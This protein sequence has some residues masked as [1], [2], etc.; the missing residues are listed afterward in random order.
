MPKKIIVFSALACLSANQA[1]A[2][3]NYA[4]K[5]ENYSY[6][7]NIYNQNESLNVDGE[8][9]KSPFSVNREYLISLASSAKSWSSI[10]ETSNYPQKPLV[11]GVFTLDDYNASAVSPYVDIK[12]SPYKITYTNA[13]I[14]NKTIIGP[15]EIT[16]FNIEGF[17]NIGLGIDSDNP[18][19]DTNNKTEA[20][21]SGKLADLHAVLLHEEMHSLGILSDVTTHKEDQ[22]DN[23]NYFSESK[24]DSLSVFDKDLR[25]YTGDADDAFDIEKEIV[26]QPEMSVGKN[27][28]FDIFEYAPYYIGENTLKTLSGKDNFADARTAIIQNGGLTNYSV[29]YASKEAYPQVYGMPIHNAD[30]DEIDLSHL[31]LHNSFMSHQSYRNWLIPME[32]ELA[33]MQDLGY[34]IDLRKYF[35]KSYYLNNMQDVYAGGY[36]EWNGSV[37]TGNP[38]KTTH[39]IGI[40]I[41]GNNNN[42]RQASDIISD[43]DAAIGVRVEGVKNTYTLQGGNKILLNGDNSVALAVT[44]GRDH[45]I[46]VEE[47]AQISAGGENSIAVGFDFGANLFGTLNDVRG[48]YINYNQSEGMNDEP[49][50]ETS[51]NLVEYFNVAGV[52]NGSRAAIYI[53]DNAYVKTISILQGAQIKGDIISDW[54][55][56]KSGEN[57]KVMIKQDDEWFINSSEEEN[58]LYFTDLNVSQYF[59]GKIQ[60][61]IN[62]NNGIYNTLRLN[63]KGDL[64][65]SGKQIAVNSLINDGN[66]D[67]NS[68]DISVAKGSIKGTGTINV[69]TGI[70]FDEKLDTIENTINLASNAVFSTMNDNIQDI[71]INQLNTDKAMLYFD[72]GDT[73]DLQAPSTKNTAQ[74]AQIKVSEN[75]A[76]QLKDGI[77]VKLFENAD[78]ILNL[79]DS[80]ANIYYDG[81]KYTLS[82]HTNSKD[83]LYVDLSDE[84]ATLSDALADESTANYIVTENKQTKDLG[85]VQGN[86]F[87]ISGKDVDIDNHKGL[88]VDG[89]KNTDGTVL[90][91]GIF[92]AKGA[93]VSVINKGKLAVIA[94]DDDIVLGKPED[95][96]LYIQN[97][98]VILDAKDNNIN[99]KGKIVGTDAQTD[100]LTALGNAVN[101]AQADNVHINVKADEVNMTDKS[102]NTIWQISL[103]TLNVE[104]D[105][106]L[107]AG[108]NQLV[109]EGGKINFA[110]GSANDI[111]LGKMILNANT[112]VDIDVDLKTQSADHFIFEK[113]DYLINND[114]FLKI[115]DINIQG[116]NAFLTDKEYFIPFVSTDFHNEN[117][118]GHAQWTG[119]YDILTP[120]YKYNLKYA[121]DE[122]QGGFM[123]SRGNSKQYESYN[124]AVTVAPVAAL[125][126]GYLSQLNAYGEAFGGI[127]TKN[128][129][130]ENS[131]GL[132]SGDIKTSKSAWIRPYSAFEKVDLKHA[133]KIKNNMYGSYFGGSGVINGISNGWEYQDSIYAGYNTSR[134][135]YDGNSIHQY[136]VMLGGL[137]AWYK[138]DFFVA[139]TA[140]IGANQAKAKTMYGKEDF[141]MLLAG[142]AAKTGYNWRPMSDK[143]IIQANYQM[144]Y[145]FV[146]TFNYKNAAGVRIKQDPLHAL[147]L[148]PGIKTI[149]NFASGWQPYIEAQMVWSLLNKTRFKAQNAELPEMSVKPYA[150]YGIGLQKSWQDKFS[151]YGQTMFRSGG[152][153]GVD[154]SAEFRWNF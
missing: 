115:D 33:V 52:L 121:E 18:G 26:P 15:E 138:N 84:N 110:N 78:N 133:P 87:E 135:K 66:L 28:D 16:D 89:T 12:E 88:T 106:N 73:Y 23:T 68:I 35:G 150:Q 19:W 122:Q 13:R 39:G 49:D 120:I 57:A 7:F 141:Y 24:N 80:T 46:N 38:S 127:D 20:L 55:S 96:T 36:S 67:V 22:G 99:I 53:A 27:E 32:A 148:A 97:G 14:N 132:A 86:L 60:G 70:S 6:E 123:L 100:T 154:I 59:S 11:Y 142:A 65:V 92:N 34:N 42:I 93:D 105:S 21:Y 25:I 129:Y 101:V 91:T 109:T 107:A 75:M 81:K 114:K 62:G 128:I 146:N 8:V 5:G 41:Y 151:V 9:L 134:Q 72:L 3:D 1:I 82:Q 111:I 4:V 104:Q 45:N 76:K 83:L 149:Y 69:S 58:T 117:L 2:V 40:H 147:N 44:W 119:N 54:N 137:R 10:I 47:N 125:V 48:S 77:A 79:A 136:G 113:S 145:S 94:E 130:T 43:G 74:I 116:K 139:A 85:T 153:K 64:L 140:N 126:G 51:A 37:Y 17:I 90:K 144:S 143:W 63:N 131:Q 31:E 61:N 56:L 30:D 29:S 71:T 118:L 103:G 102:A 50:F 112:V 108:N 95:N 124:P 98:T 152:R